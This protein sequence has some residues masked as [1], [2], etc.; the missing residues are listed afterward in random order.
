MILISDNHEHIIKDPTHIEIVEVDEL[1]FLIKADDVIMGFTRCH[2]TA[3]MEMGNIAEAI[4]SD[5]AYQVA[6]SPE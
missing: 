4:K 6:S 5:K 2:I 3:L 1:G